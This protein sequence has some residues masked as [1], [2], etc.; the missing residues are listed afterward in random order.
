MIG[1]EH[2]GFSGFGIFEAHPPQVVWIFVVAHV[3]VESNRLIADDACTSIDWARIQSASIEIALGSSNEEGSSIVN[4]IESFEIDVG[5]I[6]DVERTRLDQQDIEYVDIVP[7]AVGDMD[8]AGYVPLQIEQRMNLDGRFGGSKLGPRKDR[9][10][11]IDGGRIERVSRSVPIDIQ[12]CVGIESSCSC[13][14]PLGEVGIDAPV[15][16]RVGVGECGTPDRLLEAHVVELARLRGQTNFDVAQTLA[17]SQ[18][19]KCHHSKML[20]TRKRL[21]VMVS[22]ITLD[23][24]RKC[25]P[26]Q[27]VHQLR[28]QGFAGVHGSDLRAKARKGGRS[29]HSC[30]SRHHPKSHITS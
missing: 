30:S 10:A 8:K 28:K 21:D 6:H 20:R 25:C 13:D 24:A 17:V 26:R 18:L 27:E 2:Q 9:Q 23:D 11:K 5:P 15:S 7:L 12:R 1:Q 14:Q 16:L 19:S 22:L 3:T 29:C 4:H